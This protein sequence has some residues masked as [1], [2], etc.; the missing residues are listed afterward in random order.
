MATVM[1]G[2]DQSLPPG[3]HIDEFVVESVLG[4]GG[5]SIVYLA[6]P[7]SDKK[8]QVVIK[9]YMPSSLAARGKDMSVIPA[10]EHNTERF[11]HGRRLFFQEA[12]TLTTLKHPNIVNVINFFRQNGTVYMVMEYQEGVNLQTYIKKH[13]GNLSESFIKAVLMPLLDGLQMIHSRG[14]LHLDIKPSNIHL[15][16]GANPL[17]LDF[18]AVHEMM[19][20]R[21]FQPNQVITP[22]F[23]PIEQLDPGGYV[24]PWT[25]IYAIGATMRACLEGVSPPPSPQRREKDMLRPAASAFRKKYSATLLEAVDWA[26]EVDP[27]LRPQSVDKL[28]EA[29]N[30]KKTKPDKKSLFNF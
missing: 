11:N 29:L 28:I 9:E 21:Q 8:E 24:G 12:S 25:D 7:V 13:K 16:A 1:T 5:F 10:T 2:S 19:Q 26:M 17:L 18:G 4:G 20:T 6:H 14:L 3:T 23:S 30:G 15:R 22:G 27:L